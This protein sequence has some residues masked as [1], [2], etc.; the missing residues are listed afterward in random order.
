MVRYNT[1][2]FFKGKVSF[3]RAFLGQACVNKHKGVPDSMF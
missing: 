1:E 2:V 3:V